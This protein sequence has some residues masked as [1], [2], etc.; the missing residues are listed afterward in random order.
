ML[1]RENPGVHFVY[2]RAT[3]DIIRERLQR[4]TNHFMPPSLLDSQFAIL[5]EPAD[6]LVVDAAFPVAKIVTRV[7]QWVGK[8]SRTNHISF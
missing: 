1:T 7:L 5:E 4:R 8:T 3:P 6:A 2:L